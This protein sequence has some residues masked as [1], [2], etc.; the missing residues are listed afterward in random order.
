MT[1]L[2]EY[3]TDLVQ[4]CQEDPTTMGIS[5]TFDIPT[6]EG[7]LVIMYV[8]TSA[9]YDEA[10]ELTKSILETLY[11]EPPKKGETIQ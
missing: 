8:K 10:K 5:G 11:P 9:S 7:T 4:R 2:E 3:V 6:L 1:R